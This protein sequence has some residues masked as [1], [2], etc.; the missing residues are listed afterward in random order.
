MAIIDFKEIAQANTGSGEQD[1]FELFS[2]DFLK[3]LGLQII[4]DPARGADGGVDLIVEEIRTGIVG[5]TKIRWLVSCKHFA[6]SEKGRS[7]SLKDEINIRD[8]VDRHN[9]RGFIGF[10]STIAST[11]LMDNLEGTRDKLE[12]QIFDHRKIE[13]HLLRSSDGIKIAKRYFPISARK[14]VGESPKPAKL[15]AETP[16]LKCKYCQKELLDPE[17]M[18]IIVFW[19]KIRKD[20]ENEDRLIEEIYWCCKGHCDSVL[21]GSRRQ[22]KWTDS[23]EEI[24]DLTIPVVFVKWVMMI[25]NGHIFG[26]QYSDKAFEQLKDLLLN[27]FPY[28]SREHTENKKERLQWLYIVPAS[29]G[30]LGH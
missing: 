2:R 6:H 9:C 24:S 5:E 18:G 27:V 10:Y 19:D 16:S 17:A 26:T 12:F 23:W 21:S 20:Y 22:N 15:F 1:A 3:H 28:I 14:W 13:D 11:G 7:V 29:L 30:G 8:R 4:S 25:L